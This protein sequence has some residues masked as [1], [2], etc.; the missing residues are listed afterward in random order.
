M[1]F[2]DEFNIEGK[3]KVVYLKLSE[4]G[5]TFNTNEEVNNYFIHREITYKDEQ[6]IVTGIERKDVNSYQDLV[7]FLIKLKQQ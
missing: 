1:V 4:N 5:F 6:Y 7:G 2:L 3:E